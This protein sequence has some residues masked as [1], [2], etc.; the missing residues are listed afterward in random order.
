MKPIDLHI[1]D[2]LTLIFELFD[3]NVTKTNFVEDRIKFIVDLLLYL[4]NNQKINFEY[5]T[6]LIEGLKLINISEEQIPADKKSSYIK[7]NNFINK[8]RARFLI[9]EQVGDVYDLVADLSKQ[10]NILTGLVVRMYSH[11]ELGIN[12]PEQI[13]QNYD[14]FVN[15]YRTMVDNGEYK[16]RADLEDAGELVTKLMERNMVIAE[17]VKTEYLDKKK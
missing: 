17:I 4:V 11:L 8:L 15:M 3:L 7:A 10:I 12:Y 16:D 14:S 2:L 9:D 5:D 13:K 6:E 1:R